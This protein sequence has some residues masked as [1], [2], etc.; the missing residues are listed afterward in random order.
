ML[1][2]KR[3]PFG[4]GSTIQ[5]CLVDE[6]M[7]SGAPV[8]GINATSGATVKGCSVHQTTAGG[9]ASGIDLGE[10]SSVIDSTVTTTGGT[11]TSY[12]IRVG[13]GGAVQNCNSQA[14]ESTSFIYGIHAGSN[15]V[16]KN[17]TSRL[18]TSSGAGAIGI[19]GLQAVVVE[20]CTA[21]NIQGD[22]QA[23]GIRV[24]DDSTVRHSNSFVV[25]ADETDLDAGVGFYG[26]TARF[27]EC[28]ARGAKM[29]GFRVLNGSVVKD[30]TA[31]DN[32]QANIGG[33][34]IVVGSGNRIEGNHLWLNYYG[35]QIQTEDGRNVVIR[36]YAYSNTI[37][38]QVPSGNFQGPL[39]TG[40]TGTAD[41]VGN[42]SY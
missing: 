22:T 24:S 18:Q 39:I 14:N 13:N 4:V 7:G 31:R 6:T 19:Q 5:N 38:Y 30:C 9:F 12:G 8:Y 10:N 26:N 41:P 20:G 27:V 35:V 1:A 15:S 42:F 32:N 36:N 2:L 17:S 3:V 34:I 37:N 11:S 28:T 29:V 25:D 23:F 33:G 40:T 16:I 21:A